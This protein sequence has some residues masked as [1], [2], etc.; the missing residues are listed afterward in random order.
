M[1]ALVPAI[2]VG[3]IVGTSVQAQEDKSSAKY[4][5][6]YCR[7]A[8]N[9]QAPALPLDAIMQG[10]CVGIIDALSFMT[11]EFPPEEKEYKTCPPNNVP[12]EQTV[13]VVITYIEARPQRMN[14]PF[15]KLAIEA[16]HDAWPCGTN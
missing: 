3:L 10:M 14:E 9:N 8:V 5:L 7:A 15:K 6:R 1:R 12:L 16:I 4:M 13:R 2:A 11:S